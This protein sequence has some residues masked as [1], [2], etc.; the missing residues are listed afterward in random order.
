MI[1]G[2]GSGPDTCQGDSGGPLVC[3]LRHSSGAN[4]VW[5]FV[6]TNKIKSIKYVLVGVTSWGYGCGETPGVY[7][8]VA[9][10]VDW[11]NRITAQY[12]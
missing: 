10:H 8:E 7:C 5:F 3:A 4:Q 12:P 9:D 2:G 11:I 6:K 1:C